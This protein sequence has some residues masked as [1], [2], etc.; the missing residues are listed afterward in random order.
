MS[1]ACRF[2][3]GL[4]LTD[5]CPTCGHLLAVHVYP[6]KRCALCPALADIE[7]MVDAAIDRRLGVSR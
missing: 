7:K 6:S 1:S 5:A 4:L 3:D 2:S